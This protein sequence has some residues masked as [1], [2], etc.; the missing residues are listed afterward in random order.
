MD[1]AGDKG[2]DARRKKR[3]RN[4]RLRSAATDC[5]G[6]PNWL[7]TVESGWIARGQFGGGS[8][9]DGTEPAGC[10]RTGSS[11]LSDLAPF[12]GSD[13]SEYSDK[14]S[15]PPNRSRG[16]HTRHSHRGADV[17]AHPNRTTCKGPRF[18]GLRVDCLDAAR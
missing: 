3:N 9:C 1:E 6:Q 14:T 10:S 7:I 17:L 13:Q 11:Y 18:L 5:A 16:L 2:D 8:F 12:A 15:Q 4:F